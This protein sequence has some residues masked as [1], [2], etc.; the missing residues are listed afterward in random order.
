V[1]LRPVEEMPLRDFKVDTLEGYL[2][3]IV[4]DA[5]MPGLM[6]GECFRDRGY[7]HLEQFV[8]I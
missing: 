6:H 4:G 7:E 2:L 5:Y 1:L 8:L 3:R